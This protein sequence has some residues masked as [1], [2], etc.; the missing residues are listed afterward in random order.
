MNNSEII[1]A[2]IK[3]R[4]KAEWRFRLYGLMALCF[5]GLC[6]AF[7]VLAIAIPAFNGISG[8]MVRVDVSANIQPDMTQ[9]AAKK[10]LQALFPEAGTHREKRSIG[11]LLAPNAGSFVQPN[12]SKQTVN[13]PL[14]SNANLWLQ[15]I[16][17]ASINQLQQQAIMQLKQQGLIS[18]QINWHFF[19]QGDSRS[20][21]KA[22][23]YAAIIGS[24]YLMMI[25]LVVALP[26]GVCAA[27]YLEEFAPK[28]K[29]TDIIEININ[30]LTSIPSIIYGL[31][32]LFVYLHLVGLPRSSALAGGLTLALMILPV[33]IIS[34]RLALK[35]VPSSIRAAAFAMGASKVQVVT[36]HLLPQAMGGIVT[37]TILGMARAIGE[38][39]PLLMIGMV[40]FIIDAPENLLDPAT[41]MPVQIYIWSSNPEAGFVNKTASGIMLLII[42]LFT[43]NLLAN[44]VRNRA[45]KK[46]YS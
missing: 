45:E 2:S 34:T 7:L 23:F 30:N 8:Y 39:A 41:A 12:V 29:I 9:I 27:I 46:Y 43:F 15:G 31:L 17:S 10:S 35:A 22:G 33:I 36:H 14:A 37:G 16:K 6:L 40:A 20:P 26:I 1:V 38:T 42:I 11:M 32:G 19:T 44:I 3:K 5:S 25:C 13:L 21:E 4:S 24:L 28:G 18:K